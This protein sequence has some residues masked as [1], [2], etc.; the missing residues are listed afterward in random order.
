MMH[1]DIDRYATIKSPVHDFDPRAKIVCIVILILSVML[2]ND[3]IVLCVAFISS[4]ILVLL[5]KLPIG[6]ILKRVKWVFFFV[7]A[8]L[9]IIP[10]T[11][12]GD[13]LYSLGFITITKQGIH[14]ASM[15]S[16]KALSAALLLFPIVS[17]MTFITF[18]R[19][20]EHLRIPNK[21]VQMISFIYRYIFVIS[22]ELY[23]TRLSVKSRNVNEKSYFLKHQV[24]GNIIG[25]IM[26]RS[27]ERGERIRDAMISRGYNGTIQSIHTFKLKKI[28]ILKFSLIV[29]WSLLLQIFVFIH[30]FEKVVYL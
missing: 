4:I 7:I 22:D 15:I 28:D 3:L 19:A 24:L 9:I 23:K 14:L 13:V 16:L 29:C 10:I 8:L 27:Y 18:I 1:F 25:M 26:I 20:I 6:F 5:S 17:T 21:I 30:V 12:S 11:T 2:I